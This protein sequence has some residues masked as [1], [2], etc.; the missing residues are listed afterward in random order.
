MYINFN[1][2]Q[3]MIHQLGQVDLLLAEIFLTL[4]DVIKVETGWKVFEGV[5]SRPKT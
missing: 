3:Q 2:L 1:N 4:L 5:L